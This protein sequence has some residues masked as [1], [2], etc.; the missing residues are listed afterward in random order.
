MNEACTQRHNNKRTNATS[1]TLDK[2]PNLQTTHTEI[3]HKRTNATC[4][5]LTHTH[6]LS[7]FLSQTR[8]CRQTRTGYK[9]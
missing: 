9:L 5:L 4:Q 7:L 1:T 6:T 2:L 3:Q 8:A